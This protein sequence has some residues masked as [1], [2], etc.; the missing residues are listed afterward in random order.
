MSVLPSLV[1]QARQHTAPP[2]VPPLLDK[3]EFDTND[4]YAAYMKTRRKA[5]ER[6]R[7]FHRPPRA[8]RGAPQQLTA[9]IDALRSSERSINF[10]CDVGTGHKQAPSAEWWVQFAAQARRP[11]RERYED[12]AAKLPQLL[13][14]KSLHAALV[15]QPEHAG[16]TLAQVRRA[17]TAANQHDKARWPEDVDEDRRHRRR[18]KK[19][20]STTRPAAYSAQ[21]QRKRETEREARRPKLEARRLERAQK[22]AQRAQAVA[23]AKWAYDLCLEE[24]HRAREYDADNLWYLKERRLDAGC[25]LRI[26]RGADETPR[27]ELPVRKRGPVYRSAMQW[28]RLRAA[29]HNSEDSDAQMAELARDYGPTPPPQP[30]PP[31][32]A[33]PPPPPPAA[34]APPPAAAQEEPICIDCGRHSHRDCTCQKRGV[35]TWTHFIQSTG[36]SM[37]MVIL[38]PCRTVNGIECA[39]CAV[40]RLRPLVPVCARC[41]AWNVE[42]GVCVDRCGE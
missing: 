18:I 24:E 34:P 5:K 30:P 15:Q 35:A 19:G 37:Q 31:P 23:V 38:E 21:L 40:D 22:N 8:R 2:P 20:V 17:V 39:A 10:Q 41:G 33:P 29:A 4:A 14:A 7:D 13:S 32:A 27:W 1:S 36:A 9:A 28:A 16:V 42:P 25:A 11:A 6:L 26:A 3:S 12:A